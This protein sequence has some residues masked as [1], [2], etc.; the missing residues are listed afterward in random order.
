MSMYISVKTMMC[1]CVCVCVD[2]YQHLN[3]RMCLCAWMLRCI[4]HQASAPA[5][6]SS[7]TVMGKKPRCDKK[8][9]AASK[10]FVKPRGTVRE[11]LTHACAHV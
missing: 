10:R 5:E 3:A 7:A 2:P 11:S 4:D 9:Q 1:V 6:A 8:A